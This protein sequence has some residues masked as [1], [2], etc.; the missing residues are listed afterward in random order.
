MH[1]RPTVIL[2][3]AEIAAAAVTGVS[4]RLKSVQRLKDRNDRIQGGNC[5]EIDIEGA[6]AEA[7]VAKYLGLY[8]D[9]SI[10]RYHGQGGDVGEYQVR[11]TS[12]SDGHLLLRPVDPPEPI[13]ILVRGVAPRFEIAGWITG[14]YAKHPSRCCNPNNAGECYL[15]PWDSL[16]DP[17]ILRERH[18]PQ[19]LCRDWSKGAIT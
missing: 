5:W 13:Y 15:T 6:C 16:W 12:L 17:E 9:H 3:L 7:A 14:E 19:Y 11:H 4:R 1:K 8:W 10:G 2:S 18:K